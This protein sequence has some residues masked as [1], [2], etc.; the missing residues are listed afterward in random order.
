MQISKKE[1]KTYER[2]RSEG[3]VNMFDVKEVE[4]LSGLGREKIL[5][6][7]KN[8]TELKNNLE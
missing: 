4:G 7:M 6:I 1:F 5:F 3:Y 8:Y 2:V